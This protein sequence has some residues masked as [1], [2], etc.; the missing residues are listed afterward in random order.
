MH[1]PFVVI[2]KERGETPLE[3]VYRWRERASLSQDMPVS[4]AGRLDPMAEGKLLILI[5][6]ECKRQ[7]EY[8]GLDKEYVVEVL[9]GFKSDTGDVLGM[10]EKAASTSLPT[11]SEVLRALRGEL[12]THERAY[13]IFSSKTVG[14]KPLFMY[15]LEGTLGSIQVP[16]HP[17]TFYRIGLLGTRTVDSDTLRVRI[18]EML[19]Y[20]PVSDEPSKALGADFRIARIRPK[21]EELLSTDATYAVLTLRVISGS[22][23]YM[24]TLAER[25][26]TTLGTSG[27][28]LSIRRTRIG[29]YRRLPF[30]IGYWRKEYR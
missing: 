25:M 5:G 20:T 28:A 1:P 21:W 11:K 17:E 27:L 9:L 23:A 19:A 29:R 12:G 30:G 7:K 13:P 10:P 14:G 22:G 24:R 16:T 26:G 6:D 3:A 2:D 15:A 4:Y 18:E 8:I